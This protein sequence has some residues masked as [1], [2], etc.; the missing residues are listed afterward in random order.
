SFLHEASV[1]RERRHALRFGRLY[2]YL[3]KG[4]VQFSELQESFDWNKMAVTSFLDVNPSAI[5]ETLL[6]KFIESTAPAKAIEASA[7]L[8]E[9]PAKVVESITNKTKIGN[10]KA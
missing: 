8:I 3:K 5:A 2:A 9:T 6:H 10:G 4:D 1:L 7:K